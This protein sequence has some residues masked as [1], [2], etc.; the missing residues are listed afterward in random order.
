MLLEDGKAID[1]TK[2]ESKAILQ[3]LELET[4]LNSLEEIET[5]KIGLHEGKIL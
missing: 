2:E 3:I 4:E 1:L 5:L